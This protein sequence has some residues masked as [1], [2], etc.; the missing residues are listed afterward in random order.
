MTICP[1]TQKQCVCQPSEGVMCEYG[2]TPMTDEEM[3]QLTVAGLR[4]GLEIMREA[5]QALYDE[6]NGPPLLRREAEWNAAMDL[7][8]GA[9]ALE[10]QPAGGCIHCGEDHE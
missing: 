6:Q 4:G 2:A 5:L 3:Q 10:K 8:R 7:A 1:H 9:L